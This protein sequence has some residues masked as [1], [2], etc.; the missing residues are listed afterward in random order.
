MKRFIFRVRYVLYAIAPT[1][2]RGVDMKT[3]IYLSGV[4]ADDESYGGFHQDPIEAAREEI[5]CATL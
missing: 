5:S 3:A 4:A 1:I 2:Y